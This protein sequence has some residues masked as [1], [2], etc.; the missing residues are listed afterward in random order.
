ML[1]VLLLLPPCLSQ[2][3]QL[4][5][6]RKKR[7][8]FGMESFIIYDEADEVDVSDPS[9][10]G[11][12]LSEQMSSDTNIVNADQLMNDDAD[13][14]KPSMIKL[15]GRDEVLL[16]P[17]RESVLQFTSF[18]DF[19]TDEDTEEQERMRETA[20]WGRVYVQGFPYGFQYF[21][22]HYGGAPGIGEVEM[23]LAEPED[24]CSDDFDARL[25]NQ[26]VEG[27]VLVAMRGGCTFG[28]KS[29]L[30]VERGARGIMFLNYED[31]NGHPAAPDVRE[32]GDSFSPVMLSGQEGGYLLK[33]L[34]GAGGKAN[35]SFIP[36]VCVDTARNIAT[37][38]LCEPATKAER[39]VEGSII[40]GGTVNGKYE[41][42][43][44]QFGYPYSTEPYQGVYFEGDA[45]DEETPIEGV[46]GK[47]VVVDRGGCPFVNKTRALAAAGAEAVI[48]IN[49]E[50]GVMQRPGVQPK[51]L[52]L[53]VFLPVIIVGSEDGV[54]LKAEMPGKVMM[55]PDARVSAKLWS[56]LEAL[57]LGYEQS[58]GGWPNKSRERKKFYKRLLKEV[59]EKGSPGIV[60]RL[61]AEAA[62]QGL[63]SDEEMGEL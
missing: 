30:A 39:E 45:C 50:G 46:K 13:P 37:T 38:N 56:K 9:F 47:A 28:E 15:P 31:G 49:E 63:G 8:K 22:G 29:I 23:V 52:G 27:K 19:A 44:A 24:M 14:R 55:G 61:K 18:Q 53:E 35:A 32:L 4:S 12:K 1:L 6:G 26:E 11:E 2:S 57:A 42:L 48:F 5:G 21:R 59:E 40:Y 34:R 20:W 33:Y 10:K 51:W 25:D 43:Q 17:D 41:F 16:L 36:V 60:K 62:K 7:K 58:E 3:P 54:A